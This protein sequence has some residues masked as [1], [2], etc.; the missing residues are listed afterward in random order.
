LKEFWQ[1]LEKNP[2]SFEEWKKMKAQT[3]PGKAKCSESGKA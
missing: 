1:L 3:N 2:P